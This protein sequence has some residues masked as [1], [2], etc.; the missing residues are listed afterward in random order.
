MPTP[1]QCQSCLRSRKYD[2]II[3][4]SD[5]T[6]L[7]AFINELRN[8]LCSAELD[9]DVWNAIRDGSWPGAEDAG[10]AIVDR[11]RKRKLEAG[12]VSEDDV[13]RG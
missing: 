1:C 3:A 4:R 10:L 2:E 11:A 6:E 7:K 13:A 8:D 5:I 12:A 9:L